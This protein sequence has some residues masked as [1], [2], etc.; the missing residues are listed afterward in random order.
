MRNLRRGQ[1]DDAPDD[2]PDVPPDGGVPPD[3]DVPPDGGV[4]PDGGVPPAGG[5]PPLRTGFARALSPPSAEGSV[6]WIQLTGADRLNADDTPASTRSAAEMS[7]KASRIV[8]G[9]TAFLRSLSSRPSAKRC[10]PD[11]STGPAS[12]YLDSRNSMYWL[13]YPKATAKAKSPVFK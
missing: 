10:K 9:L 6:G 4:C 1:L 13:M 8:L 12:A 5:V 7:W 2:A 11:A 3:G